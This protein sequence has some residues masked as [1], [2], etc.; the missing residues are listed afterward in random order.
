M[1]KEIGIETALFGGPP[2][3]GNILKL[4]LGQINFMSIFA[5]PLF[6]GVTSLCP[7]MKCTVEQIKM[8]RSRWQEVANQQQAQAAPGIPSDAQRSPRSLSPAKAE[9]HPVSSV[10]ENNVQAD[11]SSNA[12]ITLD[13]PPDR[14]TSA[15]SPTTQK[16]FADDHIDLTQTTIS[17]FQTVENDDNASSGTQS[18]DEENSDTGKSSGATLTAHTTDHDRASSSSRRASRR[19]NSYGA[20]RDTRTQSASTTTNTVATPTSPATNATSFVTLDSNDEKDCAASGLSSASDV[21]PLDEHH[22][23]PSSSGIYAVSSRQRLEPND[24]HSMPQKPRSSQGF[25]EFGKTHHVMTAI[26]GNAWNGREPTSHR[27]HEQL[28]SSSRHNIPRKKSRLRLA[29]WRRKPHFQQE[30]GN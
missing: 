4:S 7:A 1:E 20:S 2:E 22:S 15:P 6:E 12:H 8:N 14:L 3:L 23:R 16:K 25:E 17:G 11:E 13:Q 29:F 18:S 24:H 26:L 27:S 9:T 19:S 28:G 30:A 21:C 10:Q 5:L